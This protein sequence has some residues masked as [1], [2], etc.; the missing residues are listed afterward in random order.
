MILTASATS[1]GAMSDVKI[2]ARLRKLG[3][4]PLDDSGRKALGDWR[5]AS[6]AE[7]RDLLAWINALRVIETIR[8]KSRKERT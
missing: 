7:R 2:D 5:G 6:P 1:R 4:P 8:A 3:S